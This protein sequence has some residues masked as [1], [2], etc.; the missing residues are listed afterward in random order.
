M[1]S[2]P[3]VKTPGY[4]QCVPL[5]RERSAFYRMNW[6]TGVISEARAGNGVSRQVE[7]LVRHCVASLAVHIAV[8]FAP[9]A[10]ARSTRNCS[11]SEGIWDSGIVE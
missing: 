5:G 3:G 10:L 4:F 9:F 1:P 6:V 2:E 8:I 7:C 11:A